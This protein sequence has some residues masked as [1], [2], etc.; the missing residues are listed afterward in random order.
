MVG[1]VGVICTVHPAGRDVGL[2]TRVSCWFLAREVV[3]GYFKVILDLIRGCVSQYVVVRDIVDNRSGRFL[4]KP[5]I[6]SPHQ[7]Q[8]AQ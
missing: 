4:V 5:S 1:G 8:S 3:M 7:T 2:W 6:A